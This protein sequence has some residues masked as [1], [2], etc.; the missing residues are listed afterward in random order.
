MIIALLLGLAAVPNAPVPARAF[1]V[2]IRVDAGQ[3]LGELA[4]IWRFFG[5]DE[6]NYATMKDGRKL[7]AALGEL[8][9][10]S[11]Y[12][13]THN[14]LTSGDGTPALKWG[15][16]NVYTEDAQGRPVYDW[17]IVD[18]IFDTYLERGV[19]PYVQ[20]GFMPKALSRTAGALPARVAARGFPTTTI[21]TGWAHPPKDYAKWE[22]LVYQWVRHCV[23][24]V[25]QGGGVDLV[26]GDLER[27]EHRLLEGNLRGVPGAP[28]PRGRRRAPRAARGPR[29]RS[30]HGRLGA[31]VPPAVPRAQ[32]REGHAPRLRLLPRQGLAQRTW[33]ATSGWESPPSSRRS[34]RASGRSRR[35]RAE[36]DADRDRRV[37]PGR[38]RRLPGAAARLSQ[39]HDV[40]ELHG[41]ELRAQARAGAAARREPRGRAHLGVRVRGPALLRGLPRPGHER[42]P[43]AGA[44]RLPHVREDGR[45]ARGGAQLRR[46]PARR[47]SSATA[48]AARPT[49]RPSRA[50]SR[51]S[52]P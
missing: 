8:K 12:F 19:R 18:R 50:S 10:R 32:P 13:R 22:E 28:R 43:P 33:T 6:P 1:A 5:G 35:S 7:L 25:R 40:L 11:V 9:P 2:T 27:G 17:T 49:S 26:L 36:A 44:E 48:C 3:P 29:G 15:S 21:Y 24:Q 20:I 16:T 47:R 23:E 45:A 46:G 30:R 39:R 38:L 51:T 42:H 31:E 14:L 41:R 37:R 34:T 4:P 52:S